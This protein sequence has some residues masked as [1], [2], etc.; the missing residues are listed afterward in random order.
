MRVKCEPVKAGKSIL[1]TQVANQIDLQF[2]H[3]I[4]R[5]FEGGV[6]KETLCF[7]NLKRKGKIRTIVWFLQI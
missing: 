4:S 7:A 3:R 6:L 2:N 5:R 1:L